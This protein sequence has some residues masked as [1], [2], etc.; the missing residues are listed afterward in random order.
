MR[1]PASAIGESGFDTEVSFHQLGDLLH[2]AAKLPFGIIRTMRG[3][4]MRRI[5]R[6]QHLYGFESLIAR[7]VKHSVNRACIH[8]FKALAHQA[9]L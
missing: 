4:V 2:A 7:T 9:L 8:G 6:L 3:H 1:I 5:G